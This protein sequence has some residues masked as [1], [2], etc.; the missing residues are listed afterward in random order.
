MASWL[1][2]SRRAVAVAARA[3]CTWPA[4]AHW[5]NRT[6]TSSAQLPVGEFAWLAR[7]QSSSS[8]AS[9]TPMLTQYLARKQEYPGK[10]LHAELRQVAR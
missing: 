5:L 1:L 8:S 10:P 2:R 4:Q 3:R 6:S 9:R 7:R